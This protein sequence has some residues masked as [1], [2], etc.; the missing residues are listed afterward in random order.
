MQ[1]ATARVKA[2][3][4]IRY[5]VLVSAP[6][7]D[8]TTDHISIQPVHRTADS[9]HAIAV[10]TKQGPFFIQGAKLSLFP[11]G[12][13]TGLIHHQLKKLSNVRQKNI[14]TYTT[15]VSPWFML[16]LNI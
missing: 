9:E 7:C 6:T 10:R 1:C 8:N 14:Y 4:C 13:H 2:K 16:E 15:T 11:A 3:L 12:R 5:F